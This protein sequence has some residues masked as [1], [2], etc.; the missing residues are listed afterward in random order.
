M[1]LEFPHTAKSPSP[2][3]EEP[4]G[5]HSGESSPPST[6]PPEVLNSASPVQ[7][8]SDLQ[9]QL[10]ESL[11]ERAL[12]TDQLMVQGQE[13]AILRRQLARFTL[14]AQGSREGLW[15]GE[16][17]P[18][19]PW[20]SSECPVWYSPQFLALVG[21]E[22]SEFPPVLKSWASLLHPDDYER[23]FDALKRHIECQIPYQVEYRLNVKG[24]E[25]R[26]FQATGE[27][28]FDA[29]GQLIRGGG[30]LRDITDRKRA[31]EA[32]RENHAL[33]RAVVEGMSDVVYAKDHNGRYLLINSS[34]A[35]FLGVSIEDVIGKTDH[36]LFGEYHHPIFSQDADGVLHEKRVQTFE[37]DVV[38][39]QAVSRT[40]LVT[41]APFV[42]SHDHPHG[43][44]GFAHD[45]TSRKAAE[46][47]I[48]ERAKRY[49][50]I[51][52]NAYDL[53]AEVDAD[54]RFLYVS[55]SFKEVLGYSPKDLLGTTIF[56]LVHPDD[57]HGAMGEFRQGMQTQSSGRF[58]CRYR[59]DEGNYRWFESTGRVF[60]TVLGELRGVVISRDI[61][62]R[63]QSEEAFE[64]IVKGTVAPGSPNFFKQ[65]VEELAKALGIPMVFLAEK[66]EGQVPRIRALAFWNA[67]HFEPPME[68]ECSQGPCAL[69]YE[70]QAVQFPSGVQDR[71]PDVELV[72]RFAVEAYY[73]VPLMNSQ[74]VVVGNL[75]LMDVRPFTLSAQGQNLVRVFAARAGTELERKRAQEELLKSQEQFRT[76]YDQTPLIY[77]TVDGEGRVLSVNRFGAQLLGY[78]VEELLGASV[79]V[80]VHPE[81]RPIFQAGLEKGLRES[82][83]SVM[84]EFRK[85]KRDGTVLWVKETIQ[86]MDDSQGLRVALLSC[87][88]ITERK[89]TQEALALSEK[90]L[91]HAQK[92]E[93]IGTLAGGIAH[94]FNNILGAILGYSE[95]AMAQV[96]QD[97]RVK[98]YLGE[99]VAAGHRARDLVKQILAFSRRSEH[100]RE[101]VDLKLVIQDVLRMVRASFP[102][103]IDIR[104]ALDIHSAAIYAD[105]TQIQQVVMNLCA[106]AEY[107]MRDHGGVLEVSLNY[108]EIPSEGRE[109]ILQHLKAGSYLRLTIRDTGKGMSQDTL[110]RIF[111][112]FF[113]TKQAGEG[114][115]LGLA[116]VH[117][118]VHNHGGGIGITSIPGEGTTCTV[119]FPRLD[120]VVPQKSEDVLEWPKGAGQVLFVDDEEM[121]TRWGGQLLTY[122][123]YSVVS[124]VNPHEALELFRDNPSAFDVVVTDQT[125]PAM[126]GDVLSRA[127][128]EIRNDI[129]IVLCT[130]FSHTMTAE[131]AKGLGI[132][133][134]LMKPVNGKSLAVTLR[135][136]LGSH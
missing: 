62:Q 8:V 91:R 51:M 20:H 113:T 41:K 95:L 21:Y 30:T 104:T 58:V 89:Q 16:P 83:K 71:F 97:Q 65:L 110:E 73:G 125:M 90:H 82:T 17:L 48:Q 61:T 76:L 102:S 55:P 86:P 118:I 14:A 26:W 25:Y 37:V 103:S 34:G 40:F 6:R 88:D 66:V 45:V 134:F 80:V 75:A 78:D 9:R 115:G 77:F 85:V 28:M 121:L 74:C 15:V 130:G 7:D 50:A 101:A 10:E 72:Q 35:Q 56:S 47:T 133:A 22:E 23:V 132:R 27:G 69:V 81:D 60:Q 117:G 39:Q 68:Y 18:D 64:A 11:R 114:T 29:G 129:P 122:L 100:R 31:E 111:E 38:G 136:I 119:L 135:D 52:E 93:A 87:E 5:G 79:L 127:I 36:E 13:L 96:P 53:I 24:G 67:D 70:G 32:L 131:K 59:H 84:A 46:I 63:K 126:S 123:G 106:N 107:A 42:L 112:P 94:D 99:V 33:L 98:S 92:M 54:G 12:L 19:T 116:V 2:S 120:V 1:S 44:L 49:R 105:P 108:E 43:V 109:G 124:S 57:R 3:T 4:H 128:L